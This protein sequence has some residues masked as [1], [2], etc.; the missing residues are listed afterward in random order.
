MLSKLYGLTRKKFFWPL[1]LI[2]LIIPTFSF[3][4]KPGLYW[5]MHDDMQLIRQMEM[6]K[7]LKD[8]QIPCRWTPDLG[9]EYGYPL[10]NFYPPLPYI[11]GQVFRTFGLSFITTVK[12]TALLLIVLSALA[13]Y[14][15]ASS[16]TGEVGG[17]LAALFYT[18]APYHAVNIYVRG[19]MNEAWATLFFPLIFYFSKKFFQN[20]SF[21]S[22][23]LLA[24]SWA[25][26]FLSH[27][28]MA[29]TFTLFF[30]P[31][32]FY[33]FFHENHQIVIKP[34]IQLIFAGFF[35]LCLSAFFTLPVLF[36]SKLVQIESMF[37]NYYHFSVHF[38]SFKE[39]FLNNYWG[40][41][42]SLWGPVDGMSF[43]IGLLYWLIPSLLLINF[44]YLS[45]KNKKISKYLL[46]EIIISMAF[47]AT[48]MTHEK[49]T[50]LWQILSPIQKIQF[51]WR[52]LNHALFLFSLSLAFLPL[53]VS[54]LNKQIKTIV[55]VFVSLALITTNYKYF[56]PVTFGPI[57]DAQKFSG[58]AW[59]NQIT[60]GIYDYLPKTAST[61][62]KSIAKDIIDEVS[63]S[64]TE[65]Q[66]QN[67][68][69]GTDWSIF[70]LKNETPAK[71]TLA[72]LYFPNF[73]IYDNQQKIDYT[74][75]AVLGRIVLNLN[76]GQHQIY[77]KFTDTPIRYY[78]NYISLFSW[79]FVSV[80]FIFKLWKKRK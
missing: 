22:I 2:I 73:E 46:P 62:A 15:L 38:V 14:L 48:F 54:K 43:Q 1:L 28:P 32:C 39:L 50:F 8:G 56:F 78:S 55:L 35:A 23:L 45:I 12:F 71:F 53:A 36:E 13:M 80:Y 76:P 77:L 64:N 41:G 65:Y 69:K 61:A 47:L 16:L 67:Y 24:L 42:P 37:E 57:T 40:D 9:Y 29:L 18:Y 58:Q 66:L 59:T 17:F 70:N 27:N 7:C 30:T 51:P 34:I 33:W 49:S 60:S 11:V 21:S 63:P 20:R 10:F 31:W 52:F 68:Q 26:L 25:G 19:A 72:T 44:I 6:E 75:E 3:L 74:I 4:L 5:N 79:I